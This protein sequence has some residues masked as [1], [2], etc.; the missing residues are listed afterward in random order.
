MYITR[1]LNESKPLSSQT[2][3]VAVTLLF[4]T[5]C[6]QT[7]LLPD[8]EGCCPNCPVVQLEPFHLKCPRHKTLL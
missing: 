8:W 3:Q 5:V 1:R 2:A 4:N 6:Q 7:F